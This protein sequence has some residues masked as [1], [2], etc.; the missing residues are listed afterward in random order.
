MLQHNG[1]WLQNYANDHI[2]IRGQGGT[3]PSKLSQQQGYEF[4]LGYL[5]IVH[6][7]VA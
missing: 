2:W 4:T 3:T 6:K 7:V 1:S 5:K